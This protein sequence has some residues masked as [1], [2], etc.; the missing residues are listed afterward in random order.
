M[1]ITLDGLGVRGYNRFIKSRNKPTTGLNNMNISEI[2]TSEYE[3]KTKNFRAFTK[4]EA[5][6]IDGSKFV[7]R[8][9]LEGA[10]LDVQE[11]SIN[12]DSI[13]L[14]DGKTSQDFYLSELHYSFEE[15]ENDDF[16]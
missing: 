12:E 3:L 8:E 6:I 11:V 15:I 2:I 13:T 4:L 9:F 16:F 1:V 10:V 5:P 14:T 7:C